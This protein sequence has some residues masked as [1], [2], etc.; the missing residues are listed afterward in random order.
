MFLDPKPK[1]K[2]DIA[3]TTLVLSDMAHHSPTTEEYGKLLERLKD[4][5]KMKE[6]EMLTCLDQV[7]MS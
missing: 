2:L 5:H 4:L 7:R 3:I 6:T 1:T